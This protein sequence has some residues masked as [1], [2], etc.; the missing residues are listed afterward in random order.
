MGG[1]EGGLGGLIL[2]I[3]IN[4]MPEQGGERDIGNM[5]V[6][7]TVYLRFVILEWWQEKRF[8]YG[9]LQSGW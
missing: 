3:L 9:L 2:N 7:L 6:G 5:A 8:Y 1:W 4:R